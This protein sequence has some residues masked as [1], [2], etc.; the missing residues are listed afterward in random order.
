MDRHENMSHIRGKNT[1]P[2]MKVRRKLFAKGFRFRAN[3]RK[4]FESP[5]WSKDAGRPLGRRASPK[6]LKHDVAGVFRLLRSGNRDNGIR[7]R[8]KLVS[9]TRLAE[10]LPS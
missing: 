5:E 10:I 2:E 9:P 6:I 3:V 8:N 1:T 7:E 4:M